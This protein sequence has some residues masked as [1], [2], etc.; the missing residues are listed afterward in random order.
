MNQKSQ[1]LITL[2]CVSLSI[3]SLSGCIAAAAG[4]GAETA[5]VA[6]Q[7]ER[8]TAEILT[9]QRI[10][11]TVKTLLL[12]NQE[13]SG[14]DINVDT[15]KSTVTLRGFVDSDKEAQKAIQLASSVSGVKSVQT[16]LIP[17]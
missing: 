4:I 6:T 14:L 1:R 12:A 11:T 15:F 9:D 16:K 17:K 13:V 10:T 2:G 5:Y 7:E 8:T 3:L